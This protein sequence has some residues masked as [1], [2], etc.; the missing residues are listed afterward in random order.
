VAWRFGRWRGQGSGGGLAGWGTSNPVGGSIA[1]GMRRLRRGQRVG[2]DEGTR[3]LGHWVRLAWG[4][5]WPLAMREWSRE[6]GEDEGN[7]VQKFWE[8]CWK[9][10]WWHILDKEWNVMVQLW[11]DE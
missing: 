1:R 10:K 4:S 5:S 2:E 8:T 6:E 7:F 3:V 9:G 11:I